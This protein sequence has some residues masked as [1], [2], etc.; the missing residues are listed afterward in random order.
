VIS[1]GVAAPEVANAV[2]GSPA[3]SLVAGPSVFFVAVVS[4][5]LVS[6]ADVAEP[7]ASGDIPVPFD[8]LFPASVV[9]AEVYS[10]RRPRFLAFPNVDH[11]ASSSSSVEVFG[12]ESVRS[13]SGARTSYGLC[14]ILSN[15]GPHQSKSSEHGYNK[16]NPGHNNRSDTNGL[17]IGAT[18]SHSRKTS[19]RQ[20]E[21]QR[22]HYSRQAAGSPLGEPQIRRVVVE[23]FQ[24]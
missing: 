4:V 23:K 21:E 13:S 15:L 10:P 16:P 7:Q 3:V 5:A 22:K 6:I 9:V 1:P 12:K 2:A 14:S 8:V 18:T 19:L 20:S 17:P 24:Y 11:Y